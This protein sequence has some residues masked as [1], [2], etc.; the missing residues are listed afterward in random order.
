MYDVYDFGWA[1]ALG[2]WTDF[3]L[4]TGTKPPVSSGGSGVAKCVEW[5][6]L[7]TSLGECESGVTLQYLASTALDANGNPIPGCWRDVKAIA[8]G[9]VLCNPTVT[10]STS[11]DDSIPLFTSQLRFQQ[12]DNDAL[13]SLP[14][15]T[16]TPELGFTAK[17]SVTPIATSQQI[18]LYWQLVREGSLVC[19]SGHPNCLQDAY[20]NEVNTVECIGCENCG[21]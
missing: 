14:A 6:D 8:N 18:A 2:R 11:D 10:F 20:P 4:G 7:P 21:N 9:V 19:A 5:D 16:C 1:E 13:C 3:N 12:C 17:L 15:S